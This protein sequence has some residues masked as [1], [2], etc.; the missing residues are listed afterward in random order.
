M[1]LNYEQESK[2]I[3]RQSLSVGSEDDKVNEENISKSCNM[4]NG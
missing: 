3:N 1:A 4:K 2:N